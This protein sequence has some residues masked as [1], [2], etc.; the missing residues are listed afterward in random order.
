MQE[1]VGLL[2]PCAAGS[3]GEVKVF[4]LT[5]SGALPPGHGVL[6]RYYGLDQHS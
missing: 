3:E 5:N 4:G 6:I 1:R 2:N